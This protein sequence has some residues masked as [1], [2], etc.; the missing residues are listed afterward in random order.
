MKLKLN[1]KCLQLNHQLGHSSEGY[2]LPCCMTD[3]AAIPELWKPHLKLENNE[4]VGNILNSNEWLNF[5]KKLKF[6]PDNAPELC[7]KF[8]GKYEI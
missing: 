4:S 2:L 8:C 6:F 3:H 5:F 7:K 1:P